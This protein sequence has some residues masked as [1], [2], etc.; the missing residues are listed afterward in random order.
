[1]KIIP[2]MMAVIMRRILGITVDM[3]RIILVVETEVM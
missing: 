3:K 2:G 1:M